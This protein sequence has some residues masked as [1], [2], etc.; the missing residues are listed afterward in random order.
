MKNID[1]LFLFFRSK[2]YEC[3]SEE[4]ENVEDLMTIVL[5]NNVKPDDKAKKNELQKVPKINS[6]NI[7]SDEEMLVDKMHT[8]L[9]TRNTYI[10]FVKL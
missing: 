4:E 8:N 6:L 2:M 5:T 1:L 9:I 3:E 7:D 10:H